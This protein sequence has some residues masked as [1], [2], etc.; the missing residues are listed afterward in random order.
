MLCAR[1]VIYVLV[2]SN[3]QRGS[4]YRA[5]A[6]D[7]CFSPSVRHTREPPLNGSRY[8][9]TFHTVPQSDVS[10]FLRLIFV[11]LSL[12]AHPDRMC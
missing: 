8:R 1:Q 10:S 11:V 12:G 4:L 9:N 3:F 7:R 6:N 2:K 5:I